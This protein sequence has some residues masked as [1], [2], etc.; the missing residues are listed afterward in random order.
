MYP[1]FRSWGAALGHPELMIVVF[2]ISNTNT[3][4]GGG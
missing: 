2:T 1:M 4:F 3:F